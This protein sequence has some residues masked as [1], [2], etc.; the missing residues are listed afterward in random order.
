MLNR[1]VPLWWATSVKQTMAQ[2]A[3]NPRHEPQLI[4]GVRRLRCI[5]EPFRGPNRPDVV[6]YSHCT[7]GDTM[8]HSDCIFMNSAS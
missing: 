1:T 8:L 3:S 2:E 6:R 7:P 5:G 4:R